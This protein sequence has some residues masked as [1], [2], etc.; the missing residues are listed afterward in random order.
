MVEA[1]L[2]WTVFEV[3]NTVVPLENVVWL[4]KCD[5]ISQRRPFEHKFVLNHEAVVGLHFS[6]GLLIIIDLH[7]DF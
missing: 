4:W 7:L 6:V 2:V 3:E 5:E 1:S